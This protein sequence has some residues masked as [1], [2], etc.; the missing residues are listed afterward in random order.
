M[1]LT[2]YVKP[3]TSNRLQITVDNRMQPNARWYSGSGLY[4]HVDLLSGNE[5]YIAPW[6]IQA[7]TEY[8]AGTTAVVL[9]TVT[10][11]NDSRKEQEAWVRV[12]LMADEGREKQPDKSVAAGFG[13]IHLAAGE[14]GSAR[15]R[16]T[17]PDA[18]LWDVDEPNL[19]QVRDS[20]VNSL[21][22]QA[23]V[24]DKEECLFGIRTIQVDAVN[25]LLLNGKGMKM[26]GGCMHHDK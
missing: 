21:D 24:L 8:V 20:L 7:E 13:K 15:I 4:R 17:V 23:E 22:G 26:K 19:Y 1:D 11:S 10:V 9:V 12:E 6:G 16:L 3:G 14:K 25:G 18:S 2:P 5:I